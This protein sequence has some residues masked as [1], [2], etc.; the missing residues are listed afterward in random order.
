M[1][2]TIKDVCIS[3]LRVR[4]PVTKKG[5][6]TSEAYAICSTCLVRMWNRS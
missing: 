4:T 1:E 2:Y 3:V 5:G 6:A